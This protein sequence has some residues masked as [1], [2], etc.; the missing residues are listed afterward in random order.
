[1][2]TRT[3]RTRKKRLNGLLATL[4]CLVPLSGVAMPPVGAPVDKIPW[5]SNITTWQALDSRRLVV[6]L[7]PKQNYLVTLNKHCQA[8]PSASHLGVSA[9]NNTV[10][11]GFDYITAD[12]E[13]CFIKTIKQLSRAEKRALT[14]V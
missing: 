8:L 12:G 14:K 2:Q 6:S 1:M 9:S 7:N 11:A 3:S 5:V 10:Y 13:R 4:A